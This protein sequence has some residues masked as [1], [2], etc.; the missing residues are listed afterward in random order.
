M[1]VLL[2]RC[3]PWFAAALWLL[4]AFGCQRM[5]GEAAD[6][7]ARVPLPV[8]DAGQTRPVAATAASG[9]EPPELE[10][11]GAVQPDERPV[12][13]V[14]PQQPFTEW[15]LHETAADAL[16]RIGAP[17][18]PSLMRSLRGGETLNRVRAAEILARIGPDAS[19]AVPLLVESLR[20]PDPLVR[21]GA[22]RALG[23]I[24]PAAAE[25]VPAL[26]ELMQD[27]STGS[28]APVPA[29]SGQAPTR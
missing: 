19:P 23:Q 1:R 4:S 13:R 12:R 26:M 14:K 22:A 29:A 20:D 16:A 8:G 27:T 25:A 7:A 28:F 24:G 2:P 6:Q 18:V 15:S 11:A 3:G 5:P 9:L 10:P 21:R 17:A